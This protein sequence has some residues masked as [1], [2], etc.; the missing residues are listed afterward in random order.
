MHLETNFQAPLAAP[1][2]ITRLGESVVSQPI[3]ALH[4]TLPP[5]DAKNYHDAQV[6]DYASSNDFRWKAPLRLEVVSHCL[7]PDALPHPT[8][9]YPL[10]GT[11]GFGFWNHPFLPGKGS[12]WLPQAVWYFFASP[13]NNMQLAQGVAGS[14]W[15][16]ATL[17]AKRWQFLALAPT[18]PLGILLMRIPALYRG[19]WPVGQQAL[20]VSEHL[21]DSRLLLERHTYVIDWQSDHVRFEVD[22]VTVHQSPSAP[23]GKL[24]F[25][26]WVDN[27][28]AVVT[29]QG[30]FKSGVV[31]VPQTQTLILDYVNISSG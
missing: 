20:G 30:Q 15:K 16:A 3:G 21:L 27:Q 10:V 22:G 19:L 24:G 26:A 1:W 23:Q 11:A 9:T 12:S 17:D 4:L 6:S 7:L 28:Y 8:S 29:P 13:P 25:I 31:S 18:A 14:G 2:H 5:V